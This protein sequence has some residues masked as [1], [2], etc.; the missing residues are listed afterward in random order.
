MKVLIV[1]NGGREHALAWKLASSPR[2]TAL[3]AAPG[4]PGTAQ[5]ADNVPIGVMQFDKI[6]KFVRDNA[7]GFVVIGPED[8]LAAGLA[9]V[10][11]QAGV[12]VFGPTRAAAQLEADKWFAKELM[13]QQA[14]PTAEARTFTDVMAA[15]DFVRTRGGPLVVKASGLAKGKGVSVCPT[16]DEALA[17]VSTIMRDKAFGDAGARLVIEEKLNGPECSI[18]AFVDRKNIYVMESAQ[19]HKAVNDRDTGPMTGGMGAYSPTPVVSEKMLANIERQILVPVVDGLTRDGIEYRGILYAGLML[20]SNGPKVLEFN[21]RFGDPET[22]P[23]MMRL[24]SD[25][26]EAMLA[27]ADGRL[28][29]VELKW[30][31]RPAIAVVATSGGYPGKYP[32]DLPITG[33]DAADSM[34]D[35]KVFH[36]GT[37]EKDGQILTDG[38]RVLA[39]TALGNTIA[40][41]QKRAYEAMK[42]IQFEGMHYRTDIGNQAVR[43]SK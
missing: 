19:D 33:I 4:N 34:P 30:D 5:V 17:A 42:L 14:V 7:I 40:D 3:Y 31:P 43:G 1:G 13:R 2:V 37:K 36:A 15:E 22:Q 27:V 6:V 8:P 39:V 16:T 12:K 38:G 25:L 29:K 11:H 41:A 35:V 32:T 18:L 28:D 26:L 20:T 24:Q 23:L 21:C 9:D 10:L